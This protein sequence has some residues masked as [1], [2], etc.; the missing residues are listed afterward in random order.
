MSHAE[1][2][3]AARSKTEL[4][5]E[6]AASLKLIPELLSKLTEAQTKFESASKDFIAAKAVYGVQPA[7]AG[8]AAS[9]P[10]AVPTAEPESETVLGFKRVLAAIDDYERHGRDVR[11]HR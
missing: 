6:V 11:P 1:R 7:A 5:P 4:P 3:K 10:V 2:L 8:S 9:T